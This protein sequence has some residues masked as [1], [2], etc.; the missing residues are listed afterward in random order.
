[1]NY[2]Y[3]N[4]KYCISSEENVNILLKNNI[5]FWE[6]GLLSNYINKY[7]FIITYEKDFKIEARFTN[8]IQ[9]NIEKLNLKV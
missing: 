3:F 5:K 9:Y 8:N 7:K 4:N 2:K 1:M 6:I